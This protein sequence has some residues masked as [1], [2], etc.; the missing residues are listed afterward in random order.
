MSS[1]FSVIRLLTL[2]R[3]YR[4]RIAWFQYGKGTYQRIF[5]KLSCWGWDASPPIA[6]LGIL[7]PHY[8]SKWFPN[9]LCVVLCFVNPPADQS[10][11]GQ[12][13]VMTTMQLLVITFSWAKG[14]QQ[15]TLSPWRL[16][17]LFTH[18]IH[19]HFTF[20]FIVPDHMYAVQKLTR[21]QPVPIRKFHSPC[22]WSVCYVWV[23]FD[24]D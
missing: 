16:I 3:N 11:S 14:C 15:L 20:G 6:W 13:K 9:Y 2:W 1:Y 5:A 12:F 22:V 10:K 18:K 4:M 21:F 8:V 24:D 7:C 17:G 19:T 23:S